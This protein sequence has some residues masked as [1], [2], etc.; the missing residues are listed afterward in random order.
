[1]PATTDEHHVFIDRLEDEV[2]VLVVDE[3]EELLVP[4]RL[5]PADA[6]EGDWLRLRLMV[7][8]DET[9]ARRR[10]VEERRRRL[11]ADDD[12]GDLDL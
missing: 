10:A 5:L 12:G 3:A 11:G 4:R 2:A 9:E 8:A 6:G 1:M 7:D